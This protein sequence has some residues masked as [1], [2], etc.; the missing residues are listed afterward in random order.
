MVFSNMGQKVEKPSVTLENLVNCEAIKAACILE[1][2]LIIRQ[3]GIYSS[4]KQPFQLLIQE[5]GA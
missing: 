5:M 3:K 1:I 2:H 4:T